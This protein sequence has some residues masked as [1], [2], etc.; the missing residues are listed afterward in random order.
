[1]RIGFGV[2]REARRDPLA[3]CA[4]ERWDLGWTDG[5]GGG[6]GPSALSPRRVICYL[7]SLGV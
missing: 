2:K 7:H 4:R 3:H 5:E 1:M 6:K